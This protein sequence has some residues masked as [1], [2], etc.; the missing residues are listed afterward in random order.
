[1]SY[2]GETA[3]NTRETTAYNGSKNN[4]LVSK[5]GELAITSLTQQQAIDA[6]ISM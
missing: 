2:E 5:A 6:C 4:L 1:M 3:E